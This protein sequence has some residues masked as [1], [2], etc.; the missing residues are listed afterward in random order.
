VSILS[1]FHAKPADTKNV[2]IQSSRKYL[3]AILGSE[4]VKVV[5]KMLMKLT[6]DSRDLQQNTLATYKMVAQNHR[7]TQSANLPSMQSSLNCQ[8]SK[9][10]QKISESIPQ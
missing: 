9:T 1:T 5:R 7:L 2:K 8:P 4:G 3:F 6:P 10:A